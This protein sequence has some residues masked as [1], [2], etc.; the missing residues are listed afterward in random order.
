MNTKIKRQHSYTCRDGKPRVFNAFG[1]RTYIELLPHINKILNSLF[2]RI[3]PT[4]E[5]KGV[6]DEEHAKTLLIVFTEMFSEKTCSDPLAPEKIPDA[7]DTA[8]IPELVRIAMLMSAIDVDA[9]F[10]DLAGVQ[11][12]NNENET[13]VPEAVPVPDKEN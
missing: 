1:F 3:I 12:E 2:L 13:V 6:S 7:I 11:V 9:I 5:S 8:D 10:S 4:T